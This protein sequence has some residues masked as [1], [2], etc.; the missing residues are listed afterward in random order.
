[1]SDT[2]C[3]RSASGSTYSCKSYY[4]LRSFRKEFAASSQVV[5]I[6]EEFLVI[7]QLSKVNLLLL[8]DR[9]MTVEAVVIFSDLVSILARS[10]N[11]D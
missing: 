4:S 1:M 9:A 10:W 6:A 2:V 5:K 3:E 7:V 8:L 11:L